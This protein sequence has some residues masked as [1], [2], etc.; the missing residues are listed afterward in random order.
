MS[1]S[2]NRVVPRGNGKKWGTVESGG[3]EGQ[4]VQVERSTEQSVQSWRRGRKLPNHDQHFRIN[5]LPTFRCI[6]TKST[7][8]IAILKRGLLTCKVQDADL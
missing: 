5:Q 6:L 1:L 3:G 2:S 7:F 4:L 8:N